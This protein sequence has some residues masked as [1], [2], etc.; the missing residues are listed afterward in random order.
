M[1]QEWLLCGCSCSASSGD[2]SVKITN[3]S[4][5]VTLGSE[6]QFVACDTTPGDLTVT[7]PPT[8]GNH[9]RVLIIKH[10]TGVHHCTV[11]RGGSDSIDGKKQI[12][13][14]AINRFLQLVADQNTGVWYV[15]SND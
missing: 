1:L 11:I 4:Q 9:G 12:S 3:V 7:L 2:N 15:I 8:M 6:H 5:T 13:L 10:V 14:N